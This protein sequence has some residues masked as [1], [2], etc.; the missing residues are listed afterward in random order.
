MVGGK[1]E[2]EKG[3]KDG[4]RIL[5]LVVCFQAAFEVEG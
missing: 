1:C 2:E 5:P 3:G 4:D